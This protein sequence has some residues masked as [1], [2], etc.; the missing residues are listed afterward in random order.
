MMQVYS[1]E[2]LIAQ[3]EALSRMFDEVSLVDPEALLRLDPATLQPVG[4]ADAVPMLD[5]DGR[6]WQP[7]ARESGTVIAFYQAVQ[8]EARH[9]VLVTMYDLPHALS[10]NTREANAFLRLLGQYRDELRHDY[11]TGVYS[12]AVLDGAFRA[13]VAKEA[14]NGPVS[15]AMVRVNEYAALC[16]QEG[17]AAAD[18]CLNTAAGILQIAVGMDRRKNTLVRLEDG[19]FLVVALGANA[20]DLAKHLRDAMNHSRKTFSITLA[21][22]G[23]FTTTVAAA[24]WAECGNWDM[25]LSLVSQRL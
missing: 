11:V 5:M 14:R 16:A 8:V 2:Q 12:R 15:I 17:N 22:R 10:G 7:L 20:H 1:P 24:D 23:E 3:V 6:A 18:C 9:C 4:P 19:T 25:L 13:R 21:R